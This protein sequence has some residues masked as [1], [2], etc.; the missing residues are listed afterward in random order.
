MEDTERSKSGLDMFVVQFPQCLHQTAMASLSEQIDR[1][2][3]CTKGIETAAQAV[4][5][6][7]PTQ[8][9]TFAVLHTQLGDL[10]RDIDDSEIGLFSVVVPNT[11]QERDSVAKAVPELTRNDFQVA[12]PLRRASTRR[13]DGNKSKDPDPEVYARAALRYIHR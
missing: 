10:I 6:S 7:A 2:S 1:L 3:K 13:D 11:P 5:G 12:T 8:S 9:F 4:S